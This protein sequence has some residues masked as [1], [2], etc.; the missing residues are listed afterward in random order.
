MI[1]FTGTVQTLG[2]SP[3]PLKNGMAHAVAGFTEAGNI[4]LDSGDV[5]SKDAAMFRH[6]FV[7]T[8]IGSQG[9]T[10]RRVL[11]GM[12]AAMGKAANMQQ[13]YVSATRAWEWVRV[14]ADDQ[15]AA[16]EAARR[17]SR[18]LLATDLKP[19]RPRRER[20]RAEEEERRRIGVLHKPFFLRTAPTLVPDR[21]P[22]TPPP[23]VPPTPQ[24][25]KPTGPT[26]AGR[27]AARQQQERGY[28]AR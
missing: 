20:D 19:A 7:E 9:R 3:R 10:V 16:R 15:D 18:Q 27:L 8:S 22:P 2:A 1:R 23:Y 17:D 13:L 5:I 28:H 4:R 25:P 6:G 24:A 11:L 26:H 14:Y 21:R 12:S